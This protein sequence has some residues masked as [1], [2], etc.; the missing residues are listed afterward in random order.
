[1]L[2]HS[3]AGID[4]KL[5]IKIMKN[6]SVHSSADIASFHHHSL[7]QFEYIL[8]N[9]L[10]YNQIQRFNETVKPIFL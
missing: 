7:S 1:M 3:Q 6:D 4:T 10:V 5:I 8:K 2:A 9:A